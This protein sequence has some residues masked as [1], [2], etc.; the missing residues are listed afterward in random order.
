MLIFKSAAA[1][2]Y[3]LN[4]T[5]YATQKMHEHEVAGA[6]I[7]IIK[8]GQLSDIVYLG[9]ESAV[10]KE[11]VGNKSVFQVGSVSKPVAAWAAMTLVRDGKLDLDEPVIRYLTRWN[12][13]ESRFDTNRVTL[14]QLLSH[15]AGLRL[16]GY[17]GYPEGKLLP[18][19][20]ESL[21]GR[22]NGSGKVKLFQEPGKGF[23]YSGGGYTLIQLLVEEVSGMSFSD[24]AKRAVLDP[25]GMRDSSYEPNVELLQRRIQPHTPSLKPM[26][27]HDFRA[28]A[29]ASLHTTAIDLARFVLANINENTILNGDTVALM[30]APIASAGFADIGLGFFISD[31]GRL[32]GHQ[33][34]NFGWRAEIQFDLQSGEGLVVMTNSEGATEFLADIKCEWD[35]RRIEPRLSKKCTDRKSRIELA[36]TLA[37]LIAALILVIISALIGALLTSKV[38]FAL[39]QTRVKLVGLMTLLILTLSFAVFMYTSMGV[40]LVA[41]FSSI[42]A[43]IHYAPP[44]VAI[45]TPWVFGLLSA[46]WLLFFVARTNKNGAK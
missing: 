22:T 10:T 4:F 6:S 7:G 38:R 20:E 28:Q 36:N 27:Q 34:A 14:R 31:D 17:G 19:L 16:G 21:S 13:P 8:N 2:G 15:T 25:L 9:L 26:P 1:L 18:T 32:V 33:G 40:Y 3:E 5:D 44:I 41:G 43:T 42:F 24:Y 45:L 39:P 37:L 12:I 11:P 30:H 35:A 46:V 23:S 29:A